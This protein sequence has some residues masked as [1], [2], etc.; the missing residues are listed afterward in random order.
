MDFETA[1]SNL[2]RNVTFT[3]DMQP[4]DQYPSSSVDLATIKDDGFGY[5]AGYSLH[6]YVI[7]DGDKT[8]W[9]RRIV[10]GTTMASDH[11]VLYIAD[12]G[13]REYDDRRPMFYFDGPEHQA[14]LAQLLEIKAWMISNNIVDLS[15]P[16]DA[17]AYKL[18]WGDDIV[19]EAPLKF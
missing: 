8:Y 12:D 17:V 13:T 18:M 6:Q 9:G 14:L 10:T 2:S 7:G 11:A 1:W 16:T 5:Q 15:N 4:A 3:N 19:W